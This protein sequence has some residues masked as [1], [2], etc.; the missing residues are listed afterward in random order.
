MSCLGVA[1]LLLLVTPGCG[2][3]ASPSLLAG[4]RWVD[5]T[6]SWS[7]DGR[8]IVFASNRP[9][10]KGSIDQLYVMSADGSGVRRLTWSDED[11]REPSFSPDG[12]WIVYTANALDASGDYSG[13]GAIDAISADGGQ[14]RFL[15]RG[16]RGDADHPSWSPDGRWIAFSILFESNTDPIGH[17]DLYVVRPDG[18]GLRRLAVNIDGWALAWSPNSKV[19][20]FSGNGLLYRVRVDAPSPIRL[21]FVPSGGAL[22]TDI[23]WWPDDSHIVF[24]R[25]EYAGSG[26]WDARHLWVVD[27]NSHMRRRLRSLPDTASL[28]SFEVSL[29]CLRGRGPRCAV[30]EGQRIDLI[31]VDGRTQRSFKNI[32]WGEF[33]A[34]G[35]ASPDGKKLLIIVPGSDGTS[36]IFAASIDSGRIRQ[37]T[38]R[39][40]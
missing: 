22:I 6:P 36:A 18:S 29:S 35:S 17:E 25:G 20:A 30:F 38:Q 19:I 32:S 31:G 5:E 23:G 11:A 14:V 26:D 1:L 24:V 10:P 9:S 40:R 7:P 27:L 2:S 34:A 15:S 28:G 12:K 37:L 21:R 4:L 39:G 13:A 8:E 33:L 16:L 3:R